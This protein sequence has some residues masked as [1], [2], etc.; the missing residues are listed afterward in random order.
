MLMNDDRECAEAVNQET[1]RGWPKFKTAWMYID[2]TFPGYANPG[3]E[4]PPGSKT[5]MGKKPKALVLYTKALPK[6]FKLPMW[7]GATIVDTGSH[8]TFRF[9]KCS[10]GEDASGLSLMT[11]RC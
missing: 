5:Y 6:T 1:E 3:D 9:R 11:E 2:S 8:E 7:R 4:V 10:L